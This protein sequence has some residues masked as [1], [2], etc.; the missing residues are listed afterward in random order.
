MFTTFQIMLSLSGI[1]QLSSKLD[2]ETTA[3]Y[4]LL[5]VATDGGGLSSTGTVCIAIDDVNDNYPH[6][7]ST[8]YAVVVSENITIGYIIS[9]LACSDADSGL[10]GQ[11]VYSMSQLP[12]TKFSI[13]NGVITTAALLDYEGVFT[14]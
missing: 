2:Y 4:T 12:S 8:S 5:V 1:I 3:N 10:N 11:L 9:D 13:S 7:S 6:C 14:S